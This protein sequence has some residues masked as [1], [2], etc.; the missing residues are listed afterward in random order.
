[1]IQRVTSGSCENHCINLSRRP[2]TIEPV[3]GVLRRALHCPPLA[4]SFGVVLGKQTFAGVATRQPSRHG[5]LVRH[6]RSGYSVRSWVFN[7]AQEVRHDKLSA[8]T[9]SLFRETFQPYFKQWLQDQLRNL[10]QEQGSKPGFLANLLD[11]FA[12]KVFSKFAPHVFIDYG[13]IWV[14]K[15]GFGAK[16]DDNYENV[17]TFIGVFNS[18]YPC[19]ILTTKQA[20]LFD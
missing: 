10:R 19:Q 4:S 8:I 12:S 20:S 13:F 2:S 17:L 5:L 11:N 1:M 14:A 3:M 9:N 16:V 6:R 18:W 15:C 7:E